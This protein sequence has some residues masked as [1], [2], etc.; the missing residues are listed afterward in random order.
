M[1]YLLQVLLALCCPMM[2]FCQ[3]ITG[4]WKGTMFNESTNQTIDYEIVISKEN[5]K[6]TGVS[7]T[8]YVLN[9]QKYYGIKKIN[10]R[11]AKDGKIVMQDAKL[12]ENNFPGS[13][14]KNVIQLN[15][16]DL[17]TDAGEST[18]RGLFVTNRSKDYDAVNGSLSI[19]KV[20]GSVSQIEMLKYL[21]QITTETS[22]TVIK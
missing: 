22:L 12:L 5:G 14:N 15:V 1:K 18:L 2:I 10:I 4:R 7:A 11:V 8:S 9:D 13:Q 16:L 3:D 19:K 20:D 17:V 6:L 21:R